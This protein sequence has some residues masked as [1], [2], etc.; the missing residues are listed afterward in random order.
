[1][2]EWS[3]TNNIPGPHKSWWSRYTCSTRRGSCPSSL[4]KQTHI[5]LRCEQCFRSVILG[6]RHQALTLVSILSLD[7]TM[8]TWFWVRRITQAL[9]LV[10]SMSWWPVNHPGFKT[11]AR[12]TTVPKAILSRGPQ[13][14]GSKLESDLR[15]DNSATA[16]LHQHSSCCPSRLSTPSHPLCETQPGWHIGPCRAVGPG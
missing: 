6:T 14:V 3:T 8:E 10:W 4:Y 2:V 5:S 7:G 15:K 9:E 13:S 16:Q 1:M 12:A 11:I